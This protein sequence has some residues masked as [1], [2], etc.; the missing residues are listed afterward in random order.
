MRK[1]RIFLGLA[2][3]CI[4]AASFIIWKSWGSAEKEQTKG[5]SS[6][7]V[8]D[9]AYSLITEK[10]VYGPKED[11][12]IEGALRGMANAIK[13][14]YST[15]YTEKE[16]ALH[17]QT[18]AG[19]RVG[20]GIE[21][22]EKNGKFIVVSPVK[23]SPAEKAGI[24]PNDE[25]VQVDKERVEG[26][27]LGELLQLIQGEAGE[28]ISLVLY[29]PSTERHIKV[30]LERAEI[31]NK[32]VS[33]KVLKVED[34]E[35]GY[36]S[37]S[38]FGEKTAQEWVD[39]TK[40]L[41]SQD[42]EGIIVDLRDNPGGYLHSVAAVV[43]SLEDSGE[44]FAYMQNGEGATEALKTSPLEGIEK[45]YLEKMRK[46]PLVLLQ[47]DGSASASE[48]MAGAVKSWNRA[49]LVGVNSFGKGT[50]QETWD[51]QNGGELK[52]STNKWLTPKRE[53]IHGVGIPA[54]IEVEQHPLFALEVLPLRGDFEEGT[55][56]EEIAYVQKVLNGLGYDVN[57]T[58]GFFDDQTA[59]A[60]NQYREKNELRTGAV[61]DEEF[62]ES[63]RKQVIAYKEDVEHDLQLQM[64]VSVLM[65]KID[66]DLK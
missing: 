33:A 2:V 60:V 23:S 54:D 42:I 40:Q 39:A 13:D 57:R 50:V 14:P 20:I 47:N 62:F 56:S 11:V 58:D 7:P 4:I 5:S 65:H 24:R 52:L 37:I 63:I 19:Q 35:V 64:G 59:D 17:R 43:S 30:T 21:I 6:F 26:K 36:V 34:T 55:F 3:I 12:L 53:W 49:T 61:M 32:T 15:Y 29:R 18:L 28:K 45:T 10:S 27:T 31:N 66:G 38:M 8:I 1:S 46:L 48:V 25:I 9:Q 22:T 16:A 51:L 41:L 44:T